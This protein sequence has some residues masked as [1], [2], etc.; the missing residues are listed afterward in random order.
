MKWVLI[1][2]NLA[3]YPTSPDIFVIE[4]AYTGD[5]NQP[6][7]IIEDFN[8]TLE[9]YEHNLMNLTAVPLTTLLQKIG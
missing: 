1:R 3:C 2:T 6:P 8:E 4:H 5:I 9:E 7:E